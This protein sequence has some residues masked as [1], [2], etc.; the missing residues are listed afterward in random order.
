MASALRRLAAAHTALAWRPRAFAPAAP[1]RRLLAPHPAHAALLA[2]RGG[3]II[4]A[5]SSFGAPRAGA[6]P[7]QLSRCI[8]ASASR[9][10]REHVGAIFDADVVAAEKEAKAERALRR[11]AEEDAQSKFALTP[12]DAKA[13]CACSACCA[14]SARAAAAETMLCAATHIHLP[15]CIFLVVVLM[16]LAHL[17][18]LQRM[19]DELGLDT[20]GKLRAFVTKRS[21]PILGLSFLETVRPRCM[22]TFVVLRACNLEIFLFTCALSALAQVLNGVGA[23]CALVI[24]ALMPWDAAVLMQRGWA[25][26]LAALFAGTGQATSALAAAVLGLNAMF[27]GATFFAT[28]YAS[29]AFDINARGFLECVHKVRCAACACIIRA[30]LFGAHLMHHLCVRAAR[31]CRA[32]P[33]SGCR[34][35][36]G[37]RRRHLPP[38]VS[39]RRCATCWRR[40]QR[41]RQ[42][43]HWPRT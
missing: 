15:S 41:P 17:Q 14:T 43:A 35:L 6:L 36:V 40:V 13:R 22:T 9:D 16:H 42:P 1:A 20:P 25:P 8:M 37:A 27:T 19:L 21:L 24:F 7:P 3:N 30:S 12:V 5:S 2:R 33:A 18:I 10:M 29:L 11:K 38:C 32:A 23:Y 26:W 31:S 28:L 39:W 34:T 4:I